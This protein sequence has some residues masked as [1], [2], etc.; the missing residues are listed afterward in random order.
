MLFTINKGEEEKM[1]NSMKC[2]FILCKY[3]LLRFQ[4][5]ICTHRFQKQN[6]L[7]YFNKHP[8]VLISIPFQLTPFHFSYYILFQLTPFLFQPTKTHFVSTITLSV[9]NTH[10]ISNEF[11][12]NQHSFVS[13]K[14]GFPHTR[15]FSREAKGVSL[16]FCL[17]HVNFRLWSNTYS[18]TKE[19]KHAFRFARK[20]SPSGNPP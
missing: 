18:K 2:K 13:T 6:S 9:S 15:L 10:F 8:F 5:R 14:A 4:Q 20:N 11:R 1:K 3:I 17:E 12:F 7:R 19:S 16:S